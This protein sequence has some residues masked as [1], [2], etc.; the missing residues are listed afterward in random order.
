MGMGLLLVG[1][2]L[3]RLVQ[4]QFPRLARGALSWIPYLIVLL[5]CVF[6]TLAALLRINKLEKELNG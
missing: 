6:A 3:L 5:I 2:G 1:L 4:D